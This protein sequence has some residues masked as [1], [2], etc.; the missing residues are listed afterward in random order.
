MDSSTIIEFKLASDALPVATVK[1]FVD[2]QSFL[3]YR[4]A[5]GIWRFLFSPK[6]SKRFTYEIRSDKPGVKP[7]TGAFTAVM[8]S[9]GS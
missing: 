8:P 1:L 7:L 5:D 2:Q 4:H 6:E 3:G 9:A